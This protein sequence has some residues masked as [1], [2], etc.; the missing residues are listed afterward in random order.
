M[1]ATRICGGA[2]AMRGVRIGVL[3]CVSLAVVVASVAGCYSITRHAG[4]TDAGAAELTEAVWP[5]PPAAPRI[6][7]DRTISMPADMDVKVAWWRS[8]LGFLTGSRTDREEFVRPFGIAMDEDGNLCITD[9]GSGYVFLFDKKTRRFKKWEKI[10]KTRF[11]APV[12]IAKSKDLLFVADSVLGRV[13]VFD[14]NGRLRYE[15][16]EKLVRPTGLALHDGKLLVAD[17]KAHMVATFD[18]EGNFISSFGKRGTDRGDFN[19]PTHIAV[20]SN[21]LI[22]VTDSLNFRIQVFEPEGSLVRT[23]GV[24]GDGSGQFSRPKGVALDSSNHV[25]VVDAL[26]DN[27][28][29]FDESGDFLLYWGAT[30][31]GPDGFWLPAGIAIDR[32]ER[33]LVADSFNRRVQVFKYLGHE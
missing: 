21:G 25:Y 5:P 7:Y 15:I 6:R 9:V 28:Q 4:R 27:V 32:D 26:F 3:L 31:S 13:I 10:G 30:G 16:S 2:A 8:V 23:F 29:V 17:A 11:V 14:E 20:D 24:I 12:A 1:K 22:Y 33:I 19:Y 18:M